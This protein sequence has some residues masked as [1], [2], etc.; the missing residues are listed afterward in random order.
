MQIEFLFFPPE[1][2]SQRL[3]D[4]QGQEWSSWRQRWRSEGCSSGSAQLE[5][6][7]AEVMLVTERGHPSTPA[8]KVQVSS[9]DWLYFKDLFA[10]QD[11]CDL[12]LERLAFRKRE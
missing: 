6:R 3:L 1:Q 2:I 12:H 5:V 11:R 4:L 9:A 7:G 8:F 10:M